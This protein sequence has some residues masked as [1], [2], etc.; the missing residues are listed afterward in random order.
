MDCPDDNLLIFHLLLNLL[1][2]GEV[3]FLVTALC[4]LV[5]KFITFSKFNYKPLNTTNCIIHYMNQIA[6]I[7]LF[8]L[9]ICY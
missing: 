6:P 8:E 5:Y 3:I 7:I 1:A 4:V 9:L 2:L